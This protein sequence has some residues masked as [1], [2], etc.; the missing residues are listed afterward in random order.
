M[1]GRVN[2]QHVRANHKLLWLM[3][4][5][6]SKI[7]LIVFVVLLVLSAFLMSVEGDYWPWYA[8]MSVFAVVPLVV[9]PRHYRI[10]GA[11]ALVL[12]GALIVSDIT[13]GRRFHSQH[14][15]IRR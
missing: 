10:M 7:S 3:T 2:E 1:I 14:P 4:A 12:S 8:V 5:R 11:V 6:T 9:G 15:E 13:A